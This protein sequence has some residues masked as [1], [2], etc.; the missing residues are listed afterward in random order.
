MG[1]L[2]YNGKEAKNQNYDT[3]VIIKRT[4]QRR[5][6]KLSTTFSKE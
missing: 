2:L 4:N 5:H 3:F 1:S 6:T